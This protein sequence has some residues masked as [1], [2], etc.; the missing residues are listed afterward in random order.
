MK[1]IPDKLIKARMNLLFDQPFFGTLAM[2]LQIEEKQNMWMPTMAVD[3]VHMFYD[4]KFV[5]T[6]PIKHLT[7]IA[8][9]LVRRKSHLISI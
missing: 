5:E 8:T 6:Q 1:N 9:L 2:R 3:G 4:P 7:T